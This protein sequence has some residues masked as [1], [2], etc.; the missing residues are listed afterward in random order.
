VRYLSAFAQR[1]YGFPECRGT[2]KGATT[3][4][5]NTAPR[6]TT[7]TMIVMTA[8]NVLMPQ[9]LPTSLRRR[10]RKTAETANRV[11]T[12]ARPARIARR[13]RLAPPNP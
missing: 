11:A 1:R 8:Q 4:A 9:T 7:T 5:H 12:D 6:I 3:N 10:I 13:V 2:E